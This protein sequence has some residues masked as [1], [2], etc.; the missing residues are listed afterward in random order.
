MYV[1][2]LI[3]IDLFIYRFLMERLANFEKVAKLKPSRPVAPYKPPQALSR[4]LTV[5]SST[6]STDS[7]QPR[8]TKAASKSTEK[9]THG[10]APKETHQAV[11]KIQQ[12]P[13]KTGHV[14]TSQTR[15]LTESGGPQNV[16]GGDLKLSE[17]AEVSGRANPSIAKRSILMSESSSSSSSDSES[18]KELSIVQYEPTT[19]AKVPSKK[20]GGGHQKSATKQDNSSE[21]TTIIYTRL[22]L[23]SVLSKYTII[24]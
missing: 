13:S 16:T 12:A 20:S 2:T 14:A 1:C 7:S 18:E 11:S 10:R 8:G 19:K 9:T 5:S 4:L 22:A 3:R 21:G 6:T 23:Y 17:T 24:T 15:P